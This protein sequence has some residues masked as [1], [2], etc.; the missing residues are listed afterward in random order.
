[1]SKAENIISAVNQKD[2][3][4]LD[5]VAKEFDSVSEHSSCLSSQR[6]GAFTLDSLL[7][8]IGFG[9]YHITRFFSVGFLAF[10]DGA[11]IMALSL[12]LVILKAEWG[13]SSETESDSAR[14]AIDANEYPFPR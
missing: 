5:V 11:V 7:E 8:Q 3:G 10:M 14:A 12:S 9:D 4:T 1:M 13:Y 6:Q 2:K